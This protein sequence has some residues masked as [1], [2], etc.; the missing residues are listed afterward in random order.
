MAW[1]VMCKSACMI[2]TCEPGAAKTECVNFTTK[3]PGQPLL[4]NFLMLSNLFYLILSQCTLII[5]HQKLLNASHLCPWSPLNRWSKIIVNSLGKVSTPQSLSTV[6][7]HLYTNWPSRSVEGQQEGPS[8]I[9]CQILLPPLATPS[10]KTGVSVSYLME[11][12][13][14]LFE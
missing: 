14:N 5:I 8:D 7:S 3:P 9:L 2:W 13:R 12:R 10:L 6:D 11:S 4:Q 1:W